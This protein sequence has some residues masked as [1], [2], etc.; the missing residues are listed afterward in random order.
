MRGVQ[1]TASVQLSKSPNLHEQ[2]HFYWSKMLTGRLSPFVV[3]TRA[4]ICASILSCE[5]RMIVMAT[6][7]TLRRSGWS[8]VSTIVLIM[9][10]G[11]FFCDCW[12][13]GQSRL[14]F[15]VP[16]VAPRCPSD[17]AVFRS[18]MFC[19]EFWFRYRCLIQV[20]IFD[21]AFNRTMSAN[22]VGFRCSGE[23]AWSSKTGSNRAPNMANK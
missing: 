22:E 20:P 16:R 19:M 15:R 4:G 12:F 10:F 2:R 8:C 5:D 18:T 13:G 23:M 1:P 17:S 21:Q 14:A 9:I 3:V 11:L 7:T 6:L